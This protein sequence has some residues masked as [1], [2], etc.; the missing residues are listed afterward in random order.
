MSKSPLVSVVIPTYKGGALLI[1]T[2]GTVFAQTFDDYEVVI[3]NDGSPDDTLE[4]LAPLQAQ[5]G[6]KLRV[7]TQANGGIGVAR[8]RGI[9]EA[10]GRYIA[11]LD[12][13][14]LWMPE[15]LAVQVAYMQSHPECVACG[16]MFALSPTPDTPHW[17]KED[18]ADGNGIVER[19]VWQTVHGRDVFQTCTLMID[20][21]KTRGLRYATERGAIEDVS[22]FLQMTGRGAYGIAGDRVLAVYRVFESNASKNPWFFYGGA[23]QLRRLQKQGLFDDLPP[24]QKEEA[25]LWIGHLAR[26]AAMKQIETGRRGRGLSLYLKE[27]PH[28]I[29]QGRLRFVLA[30]PALLLLPP[31]MGKKN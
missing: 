21:E 5:H 11:L 7:V 20:A 10:R 31:Y 16:T 8:N 9:D 14:D 15:K 27:L 3:I 23:L 26:V 24:A 2:L 22:F 18:V 4:R 13:D 29:K 1:E 25:L 17:R 30:Y 12:H 6:G 19:P 28:Q